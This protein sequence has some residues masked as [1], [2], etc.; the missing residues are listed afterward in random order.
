MLKLTLADTLPTTK[1]LMASQKTWF[2]LVLAAIIVT[3]T[4]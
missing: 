3:V 4:C 2:R 1:G